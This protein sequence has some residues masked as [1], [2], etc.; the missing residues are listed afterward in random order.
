MSFGRLILVL[1]IPNLI[2]MY[3]VYRLLHLGD[4]LLGGML[5]FSW[6]TLVLR[7]GVTMYLGEMVTT[8]TWI[9]LGCVML[10]RIA[11]GVL[12]GG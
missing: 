7:T 4:S 1:M 8:G 2:V 11:K 3:S 5:I 10:G 12:D 9:L 6:A